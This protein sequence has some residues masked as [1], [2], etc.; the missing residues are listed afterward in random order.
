AMVAGRSSAAQLEPVRPGQES[1]VRRAIFADGHLWLLSDAGT[2][3][4]IAD[5]KDDRVEVALPEPALDLWHQDG[6]PA[7][8]TCRRDACTDWA[9]R[10]R[11]GGQWAIAATISTEGDSLVAASRT[12]T[13]VTVLTSSRII[14]IV[15]GQQSAIALSEPL[16]VRGVP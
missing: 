9:V 15:A 4:S 16:R 14:D 3:S 13:T 8:I 10:V 12:D 6:Q 11:V 5:K 1:F 2:L 7:V